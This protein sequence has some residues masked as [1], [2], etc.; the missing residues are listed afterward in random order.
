MIQHSR[1][2]TAGTYSW[3]RKGGGHIFIRPQYWL[4]PPSTKIPRGS[5]CLQTKAAEKQQKRATK[6]AM[7]LSDKRCLSAPQILHCS[8]LLM[9]STIFKTC[10]GDK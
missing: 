6:V 7:A 4:H 9:G 10:Y 2:S 5:N 1:C 3:W 8:P